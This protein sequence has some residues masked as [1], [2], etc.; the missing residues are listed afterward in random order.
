VA[1]LL[2]PGVRFG[3]VVHD[4]IGDDANAAAVRG[5]EQRDEI[6]DGAE[7]GQHLVEVADVIAAVAQ[8]RV[9]E[10]WQPK[11]VDA[12]P[13]HV[14]ELFGQ[15]AQVARAVGVGVVERAHQ[16]LVEHRA[17][18]PGAVLRQRAGVPEVFGGGVFDHAV[19]DVATFRRIVYRGFPDALVHQPSNLPM[20]G[21]IESPPATRQLCAARPATSS[22]TTPPRAAF[23]PYGGKERLIGCGGDGAAVMHRR[24]ILAIQN[25]TPQQRSNRRR[26]ASDQLFPFRHR[27]NPQSR[28]VTVSA[29]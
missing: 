14:V 9:V 23:D 20:S 7:L 25:A 19:L 1:R 13:L 12:K 15:A 2:K 17:L 6:V 8:R 27:L 24:G 22:S 26:P 5:V 4:E 18:E 10:R 28:R 16:H 29:S 11:T 21:E 3:R